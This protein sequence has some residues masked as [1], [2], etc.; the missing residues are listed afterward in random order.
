MPRTLQ[1]VF[2]LLLLLL[3]FSVLTFA[4][5]MPTRIKELSLE[6]S[7]LE[8][9]METAKLEM[10]RLNYDFLEEKINLLQ[11]NLE[12][13]TL[14]AK[15]NP[16]S[17]EAIQLLADI[18]F[19]LKEISPFLYESLPVETRGIWLDNATV[20]S[21]FTRED[22]SNYLDKLKA[23]NVNIIFP[24]VYGKGSAI[25]PSD[26]VPQN[27][28]F[29]TMYNGKDILKDLITEAHKRNIEVHP[30][31]RVFALHNDPEHFLASHIDWLDKTKANNYTL[32]N[33][34][35]W[36]SP[37]HPGVREYLIAML[38]ELANNYD[39]DG[40]HLDY[41]R[42]DSDY[43]Y[44]EYTRNLYKKL[45]GLDPLDFK[46]PK[47]EEDFIIFKTQFINRFVE[48]SFKELKAIKPSLIISAAACSPYAWY[49]L[50][51]GQDWLS[52]MQNRT[53][54]F[55]TPM[56][57]RKT[58]T[59]YLAVVNSD[60]NSVAQSGYLFT[61]LGVYLFNDTVLLEQIAAG[62]KAALT[63][64]MIFS[65]T[66]MKL[67]HF[68]VLQKGPW[69]KPSMPTYRDPME[70]AYQILIDLCQR[71]IEFKPVLGNYSL[72]LEK[73]IS[74][75]E[76]LAKQ[77][78][79]LELKPW[80]TRDLREESPMDVTQLEPIIKAIESFILQ[81]KR[82]SKNENLIPVITAERIIT[83]LS[84]VNSLLLPLLYTSKPYKFI[85]TK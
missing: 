10:R 5:F 65:T 36:L 15:N 78:K 3:S 23:I 70:A 55:C 56:S 84:W 57:Y 31:V 25:Y 75:I 61:G 42:F 81:L 50:E 24:D 8:K 46:T 85:A 18:T 51:K 63:G 40:V 58:A 47:Q 79:D 22:I 29:K 33:G 4:D 41:I 37:V 71:I 45:F 66:N 27:W 52:W 67:S 7:S 39:I 76:K 48:R 68:D 80:D 53:V 32:A 35:Y 14:L 83:D 28:R 82:E 77:V 60:L 54:H 74:T 1:R 11:L 12:K 73:Y 6:I 9:S 26:V 20:D 21:F 38:V 2:L 17:Q 72:Q 44:N 59:E 13:A 16:D 43:G 34:F 49:K 30:L 64:Q 62:R 19:M 69:S